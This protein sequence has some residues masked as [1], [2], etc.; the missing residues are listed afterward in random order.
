LPIPVPS[1]LQ[2]E[3]ALRLFNLAYN[4]QKEFFAGM[5]SEHTRNEELNG[6]QLEVDRFVHSLYLGN[7]C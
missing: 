1:T 7:D 4:I 2:L 6:I 3:E 5:I